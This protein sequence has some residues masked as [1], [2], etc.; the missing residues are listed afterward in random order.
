[1][2]F[3]V[4][5]VDEVGEVAQRVVLNLRWCLRVTTRD[6]CA[7]LKIT[8]RGQRGKAMERGGQEGVN[9]F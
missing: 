8:T 5:G 4:Q 7:I 2:P 6:N 3:S 9:T 1:V